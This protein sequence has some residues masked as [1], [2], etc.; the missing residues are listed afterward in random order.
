MKKLII[1]LLVLTSC[2]E[3]YKETKPGQ[4][5]TRIEQV[6]KRKVTG[7]TESSDFEYNNHSY[8][9][10]VQG[11]ATWGIHNPDCKCKNK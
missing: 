6:N 3:Y 2:S 9:E 7:P 4:I 10:F 5:N 8:I 11:D 1:G